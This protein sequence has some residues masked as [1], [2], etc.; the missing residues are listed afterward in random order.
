MRQLDAESASE[1]RAIKKEKRQIDRLALR[2][3]S[4]VAGGGFE[5][6]TPGLCVAS[7]KSLSALLGAAYKFSTRKKVP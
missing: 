5:R 2:N 1:R 7:F 3:N 6:T 4:V